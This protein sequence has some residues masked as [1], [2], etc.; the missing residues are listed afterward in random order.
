MTAEPVG[1]GES[2]GP[3]LAVQVAVTNN[4]SNPFALDSVFVNLND[5]SGAPGLVTTGGP[6]QP[7][8]GELQPG[9]EATGTYVFT[10]PR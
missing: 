1:P 4:S 7:L 2:T 3:A 6:A 9:E 10:V 8:A 5:S